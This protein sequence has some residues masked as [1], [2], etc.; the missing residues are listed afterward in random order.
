MRKDWHIGI[1]SRNRSIT[2]S[3]DDQGN[4]RFTCKTLAKIVR[5]RQLHRETEK[6]EL[7]QESNR[8]ITTVV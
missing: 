5:Q 1:K 4:N 2:L 8:H 7:A 3:T 6:T